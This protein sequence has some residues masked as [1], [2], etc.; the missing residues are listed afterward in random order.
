MNKKYIKTIVTLAFLLVVD[1]VFSQGPPPP[2]PPIDNVPI[3]GGIFLLMA[4]GITYAVK[5]IWDRKK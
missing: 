2:P 1:R 3:D 4:A 5:S